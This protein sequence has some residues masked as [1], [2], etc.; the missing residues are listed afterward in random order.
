ML[1]TDKAAPAKTGVLLLILGAHAWIF[2][3]Q[4]QLAKHPPSPTASLSV[5]IAIAPPPAPVRERPSSKAEGRPSPHAQ[6]AATAL[7][8][9]QASI[10]TASSDAPSPGTPAPLQ[11]NLPQASRIAVVRDSPAQMALNDPRS[12]TPKPTP[13]ERFDITLGN[14]ECVFTE[15]L[16]DGSIYR[17]PGVW[18]YEPNPDALA[19]RVGVVGMSALGGGGARVCRRK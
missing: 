9:E 4:W 3:A 13:R 15:R 2:L 18:D 10:A 14:Y 6:P 17:G 12:N 8:S 16:A 19:S 1:F 7:P 11:L 5:T